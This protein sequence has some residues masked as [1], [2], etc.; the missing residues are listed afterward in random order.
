ML[1]SRNYAGYPEHPAAAEI[2]RET[3]LV[4]GTFPSNHF[5]GPLTIDP[6]A[7]PAIV[8]A[9]S[10][11]HVPVIRYIYGPDSGHRI[12]QTPE[13]SSCTASFQDIPRP[14]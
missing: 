12:Y 13:T 4:A 2:A 14:F 1:T 8:V 5:D 6:N 9:I 11:A 3:G 10:I 7:E